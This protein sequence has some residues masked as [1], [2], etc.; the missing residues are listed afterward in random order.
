MSGGQVEHPF[1]DLVQ[2]EDAGIRL[3]EAALLFALDHCPD[4]K[5]ATCLQRL[6]RLAER[7]DDCHACSPRDHLEALRSVLVDQERLE[8]NLTHYYD[9]R[10]SFLNEVLQRRVGIPIS[11]GA[12][13]L[14]VAGRLDWPI[15][16]VGLPGHFVLR[17]DAPDG[18]WFVDP[19]E[20]GRL[21][22]QEECCRLVSTVCGRAVRLMREDY[23]AVPKKVILTRMLNNLRVI[24]ARRQAW[25]SLAL[26]LDRLRAL[27][28]DN[29]QLEQERR[30]VA[31]QQARMN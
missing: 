3:G 11:L 14:D 18:V 20:G 2:H 4:V 5:I 28:P 16:G 30:I 13:W 7:V 29:A 31:T 21:I 24:Y 27:H 1:D 15:A 6:D 25:F 12:I 9:P 22:S 23:A 17:Y 8:G 19:F 26:V 10:N